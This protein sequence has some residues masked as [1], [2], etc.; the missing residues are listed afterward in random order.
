MC[1][2]FGAAGVCEWPAISSAR[3]EV[4]K[5]TATELVAGFGQ[6]LWLL[7]T[8]S[9][10]AVAAAVDPGAPERI[11]S[12]RFVSARTDRM[13]QWAAA[14]LALTGF[15]NFRFALAQTDDHGHDHGHDHGDGAFEW[16]GIF[17][18]PNSNYLWTAQKTDGGYADPTLKMVALPTATVSKQALSDLEAQ[19]ETA[20][21]A[22]DSTCTRV[23]SGGTITPANTC[24]ILEFQS[25][26]WQSLFNIDA[27][28]TAGIAFFTNHGPT[29]FEADAHY[30]KDSVGEDIEPVA[31]LPE[32]TVTAAPETPYDWGLILAAVL[33]NVVTFIGVVLLFSPLRR[34]AEKPVC[35]A[36]LFA[37]AAGA[38]LACAFFLLLFEATHLIG[39]G[40]TSEVDIVWRWG[41]MILAGMIV[42]PVVETACSLVVAARG[43]ASQ[44]AVAET[45]KE[46]AEGTA[47]NEE[48]KF[49]V[50]ARLLGAVLI[51][52][53][54]HNLCDG[55]FI[56]A[57]FQVCGNAFGWSVATGTILHELPQEIA[58]FVVLTGGSEHGSAMLR[59]LT[60]VGLSELGSLFGSR[61]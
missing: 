1:A 54:F 40:W 28:A 51:G 22:T 37:F 45:S 34:L 48:Q 43:S 20:M 6:H 61:I 50:K 12:F 35:S 10:K 57:A 36:M 3:R 11:P 60:H 31:A 4:R 52:D 47:L 23:Q 26:A 13:K 14:V 19:G 25:S 24:Y 46:D 55:F 59:R 29:E 7:D 2:D 8:A 42:P 27:S 5:L 33:V 17:D 32:A 16:A 56:G 15:R 9:C 49:R 39:T 53:F 38:L 21:E 41:A 58:D 44:T 30:L 18:T